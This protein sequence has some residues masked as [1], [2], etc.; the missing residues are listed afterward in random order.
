MQLFSVDFYCMN[1]LRV[2]F[3]QRCGVYRVRIHGQGIFFSELPLLMWARKYSQACC[4]LMY[5]LYIIHLIKGS[6]KQTR[7]G[8]VDL[9]IDSLEHVV[10]SK[11]TFCFEDLWLQLIFTKREKAMRRYE[12][13]VPAS[14]AQQINTQWKVKWCMFCAPRQ[15]WWLTHNYTG[16]KRLSFY[17]NMMLHWY[18]LL[19][20]TCHTFRNYRNQI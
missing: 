9:V 6:E 7:F 14:F 3:I 10:C 12:K 15:H 16:G 1:T 19:L 20:F 13:S 4:Y 11:S 18:I 17:V 8:I 2:I 5:V